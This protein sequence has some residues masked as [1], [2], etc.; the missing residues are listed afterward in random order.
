MKNQSYFWHYLILSYVALGGNPPLSKRLKT[1][2]QF[3][4]NVSSS[5]ITYNREV[6]S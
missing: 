5:N 4:A 3:T 1:K 6:Q 2:K